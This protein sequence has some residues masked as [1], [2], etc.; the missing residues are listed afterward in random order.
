MYWWYGMNKINKTPLLSVWLL[1]QYEYLFSTCFMYITN[2]YL[3]KTERMLFIAWLDSSIRKF[4]S[5]FWPFFSSYQFLFNDICL[6]CYQINIHIFLWI[7][8]IYLRF[9]WKTLVWCDS[10]FFFVL[11]IWNIGVLRTENPQ[12][13]HTHLLSIL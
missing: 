7:E 5:K 11:F 13:T 10:Q 1:Y 9:P 3:T 2:D 6:K 4:L 8:F 12:E